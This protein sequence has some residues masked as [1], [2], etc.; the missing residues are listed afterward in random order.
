MFGAAAPCVMQHVGG[1]FSVA[2]LEQSQQNFSPALSPVP[3]WHLAWLRSRVGWQRVVLVM[4]APLL[5]FT[6]TVSVHV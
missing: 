6:G 4:A 5:V 2:V 3:R 1:C